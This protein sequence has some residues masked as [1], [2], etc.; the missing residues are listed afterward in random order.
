[1]SVND[2][3]S[4]ARQDLGLGEVPPGSNHNRTTDWYNK[5]VQ[6]LAYGF[7]WCEA[8]VTKWM[9]TG[10]AKA[11]KTPGRAY[12]VWGA[13]DYVNGLNG[14]RWFWGMAGITTGDQV[15]FDW[16]GQKGTTAVIDHTGIVEYVAGGYIYTIEGNTS[17]ND[18]RRMKRDAK[19][20]VGYGRPDWSRLTT[21]PTPSDNNHPSKPPA[22]APKPAPKPAV[23]RTKV[24]KVQALLEVGQ[25][26]GWGSITD[27]AA[28]RMRTAAQAKCGYPANLPRA[29][30]V[31]AVQ[32]V[33][34]TGVDGVW[35]PKSQ[36]ALVRWI[37]A[38]QKVLGVKADG[39]WGPATDRAFVALRNASLNR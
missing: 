37:I 3:L 5:N 33:I 1:M 9:W 2:V 38:F 12:T 13:N 36:A 26:G 39:Q 32:R 8:S 29:F 11:L 7:A 6:N 34:N 14:G 10:G 19:F 25:D 31:T 17:F 30:N 4:M 28:A 16:S 18:C 15:Y 35:G 27:T 24:R 23:D 22:P 21:P 20:V